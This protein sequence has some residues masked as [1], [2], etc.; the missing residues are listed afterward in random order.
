M[1]TG[2]SEGVEEKKGTRGRTDEGRRGTVRAARG[3]EA[4]VDALLPVNAGL[5]CI[6][7]AMCRL[8]LLC[9][10]PCAREDMHTTIH[11]RA[12]LR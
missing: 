6:I 10:W 11:L 12:R 8:G 9:R 2:E 4:V 1:R 5:L 3:M 7:K